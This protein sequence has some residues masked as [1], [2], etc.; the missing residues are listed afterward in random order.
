MLNLIVTGKPSDGLFFY[1]C[2]HYW[3]LQEM[4]IPV[5][6]IVFTAGAGRNRHFSKEHYLGSVREKYTKSIPIIFD[7]YFPDEGEVNLIMGRSVLTLAYKQRND[8]DEEK[9]FSMA[10][11]FRNPLI[12]VYSENHPVEYYEALDY[13]NPKTTVDLCDYDV[14]PNGTGAHFEKYIHFE[15][16]QQ[17]KTAVEFEHLFLGTTPSY[18]KWAEEVIDRYPDHGI[19]GYIPEYANPHLNNVRAPVQNLMGKFNK[20]VYVKK[21]LDPAPRILQECLYY[22]KEFIFENTNHGAEIYWNRGLKQPDI[23]EIVRAYDEIQRVG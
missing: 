21:D 6:L 11:L 2:E 10:L 13:F 17:P 7:D 15:Y 16:Y 23:T 5:Q 20:Y 1:S 12:S 4:G 14:Y 22:N 8:H 9:Q 18:Y 3:K 19:V